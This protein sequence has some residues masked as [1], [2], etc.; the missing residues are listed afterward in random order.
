MLILGALFVPFAVVFFIYMYVNKELTL[1][2]AGKTIAAF[3]IGVLLLVCTL[4][5]LKYM[6]LKEYDVVK[7][8]CIIEI[9]SSGRSTE[10]TFDMLDTD[11]LFSF[12]HIPEL[13]AYGKSIPYYCEMT[14]T[15]DHMF[16]IGYKIYD[17]NS[18]ELILTSE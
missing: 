3:L 1:L 10:A 7:G 14:V 5:S 12:T 8:G 6:L 18:R 4:P 2:N 16:E 13:D 17:V 9:T 15:K 11:E